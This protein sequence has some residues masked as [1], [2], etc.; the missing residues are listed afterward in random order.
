MNQETQEI[1]G[2]RDHQDF[3]DHLV[4][5]DGLDARVAQVDAVQEAGTAQEVEKDHPDLVAY[6]D[7]LVTMEALANLDS[8]ATTA[9][10]VSMDRTDLPEKMASV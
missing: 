5:Q 6:R 1:A 7:G 10:P 2:I 8:M 3:R 4:S 9:S